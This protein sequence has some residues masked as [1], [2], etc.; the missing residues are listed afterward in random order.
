MYCMYDVLMFFL[1]SYSVCMC[2]ITV[3]LSM[4]CEAI[5]VIENS[6]TMYVCM[7]V[8]IEKE[9]GRSA[10]NCNHRWKRHLRK[11]YPHIIYSPK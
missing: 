11:L 6:I 9:I 5:H 4:C 3:Y 8:C 7:Y 2:I 10:N 1:N